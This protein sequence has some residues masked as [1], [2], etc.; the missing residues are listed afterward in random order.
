MPEPL[1]KNAALFQ[2]ADLA[3]QFDLS[4]TEYPERQAWSVQS[5]RDQ[6]L[7]SFSRALF[8][9][10]TAIGTMRGEETLRLIRLWPH[11]A[12]LLSTNPLLPAAVKEMADMASEVG[13]G[14]CQ[15]G[16]A[17]ADAHAFLGGYVSVDLAT[18]GI[19]A[20]RCV[21]CLLGHYPIMLWWDDI[22]D[23]RILIDRSLAQSFGDQLQQLALRWSPGT[24]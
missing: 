17:G 23:I 19:G 8:G 6:E 20:A 10:P 9:Q 4:V 3:G 1:Q 7:D 18:A 14:V 16:L 2:P 11:R 5:G 21:R 12:L 24:L 13:H 22:H 15:L